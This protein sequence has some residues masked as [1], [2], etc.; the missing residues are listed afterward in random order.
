MANFLPTIASIGV[1]GFGGFTLA[2]NSN[3][4]GTP[5]IPG[6]SQLTPVYAEVT[7]FGHTETKFVSH[8]DFV[9]T[10]ERR[11]QI[12]D[13]LDQALDTLQE[14]IEE[15]FTPDPQPEVSYAPPVRPTYQDS[16]NDFRE[17][18]TCFSTAYE[19]SNKVDSKAFGCK[20]SNPEA[21]Y[22]NVTW[23][24]GVKTTFINY[25]GSNDELV[26]GNNTYTGTIDYVYHEGQKYLHFVSDKGSE[27]WIPTTNLRDW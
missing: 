16:G 7:Q 20:V 18:D 25:E 19:G 27:N 9:A 2:A 11:E 5:V 17:I 21:G 1:L 6:L 8:H 10:N 12:L 3:P 4:M 14:E 15:I 22:V 26:V 24:D 23:D 13:N